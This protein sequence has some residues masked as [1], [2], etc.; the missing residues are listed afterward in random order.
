MMEQMLE[1]GFYGD[2]TRIL[3][4]ELAFNKEYMPPEKLLS[5]LRELLI[6]YKDQ[7]DR[8]YIEELIKLAEK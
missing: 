2:G 6:I 5:G 1:T 4:E 7:S 8:K 3:L